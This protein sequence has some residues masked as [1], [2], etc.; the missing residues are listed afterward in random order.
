MTSSSGVWTPDRSSGTQRRTHSVRSR[1]PSLGAVSYLTRYL[2]DL[3]NV[4]HLQ[5]RSVDLS[6]DR[7]QRCPHPSTCQFA[8]L[9]CPATIHLSHTHRLSASSL[10]V[11]WALAI[12]VVLKSKSTIPAC[13][14]DGM[15][16]FEDVD[17]PLLARE[18]VVSHSYIPVSYF[19]CSPDCPTNFRHATKC[20]ER[21]KHA[22]SRPT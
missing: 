8:P 5:S 20:L 19:V 3:F 14:H 15:L 13:I 18:T 4:F 6:L 22:H 17:Y 21:P 1:I 16:K 2:S 9:S 11:D 7:T 12:D 10:W